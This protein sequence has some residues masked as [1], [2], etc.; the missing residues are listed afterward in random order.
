MFPNIYF[1]QINLENKND[2]TNFRQQWHFKKFENILI[3]SIYTE[4]SALTVFDSLMSLFM[5]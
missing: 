2:N 1:S 3:K 4:M 5:L